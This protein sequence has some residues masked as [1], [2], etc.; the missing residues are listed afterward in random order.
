MMVTGGRWWLRRRLGVLGEGLG[1]K[2]EAKWM[3][4]ISGLFVTCKT[5]PDEILLT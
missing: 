1:E 5:C 3:F 4:Y 2:K